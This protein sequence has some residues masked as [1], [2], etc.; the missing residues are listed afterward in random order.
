MMGKAFGEAARTG[1]V[2]LAVLTAIQTTITSLMLLPP[3]LRWLAPVI[4]LGAGG[5]TF[6]AGEYGISKHKPMETP[7]FSSIEAS[8]S[9][10][11]YMPSTESTYGQ[12]GQTVNVYADNIYGYEDFNQAVNEANNQNYGA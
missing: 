10:I 2:L 11:D 9:A 6:A 12:G 3:G 7:D 5:L 1:N 4:G 8:L